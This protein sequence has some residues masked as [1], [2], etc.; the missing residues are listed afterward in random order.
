[1]TVETVQLHCWTYQEFASLAAMD[2]FDGDRVELID[3]EI[4]H[5]LAISVSALIPSP[6]G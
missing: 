1:M 3:G 6:N 2:F 5:N 4:F